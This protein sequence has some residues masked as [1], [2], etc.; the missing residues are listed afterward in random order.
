V[1]AID[2]RVQTFDPALQTMA[3]DSFIIANVY[4]PLTWHNKQLEL[5][6][7]LAL[8]WESPDDGLSWIFKL[9]PNV[10]FH[11]GNVCDAEAV[12]FHFDRI[13]DPETH[14]KRKSKMLKVKSIEALDP[15]T[16]QFNMHEPFSLWPIIMRDAFA[17][18]VSPTAV[19]KYGNEKYTE[20]PSGT[21][22]YKV[23]E[24]GGERVLLTKNHAYWRAD[25]YPVEE[26]ELLT[27]REPTTRLIMLEQGTID[28]C[29]ITFAHTEIAEKT[30][31]LRVLSAP[32]LQVR[33]VGFN[34]M[35]PPF[36]DVRVRRAANM[37]LNRGELVKFAFRG[38]ADPLL[39][40]LPTVMREFNKEM[41]TYSY[42]L[43]KA[44]AL[45][46]EAGYEKGVDVVLWSKDD[47]SDTN[48][49]VV[50]ADQLRHIGIRVEIIRYDRNV[51]WD[52]FDPYQTLDMQWFPTKPGVFDLYAAGWVGGESPH[53]YIDPLFRSTSTS[54][55]SYYKN[56]EV[57]RLLAEALK[58][59]DDDK[60]DEIYKHL[61]QVIVDDAPWI[62]CYS[63]RLLWG[64][65]PRIQNLSQHPAGEYE[66]H[67]VMFGGGTGRV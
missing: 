48:L 2:E 40:P 57:D 23:A 24:Q 45:M 32:Y 4:D 3:L 13:I 8:S 53:G 1:V 59:V 55:T 14:S 25:D 54:N 7:R 49:G 26:V 63:S 50:V 34:N 62:F 47:V 10:L 20:H 16:V 66:L 12:K 28:L 43:E 61:Q 60:R 44:R 15:L 38:N 21:G 33:Y 58:T 36:D 19:R 39:G 52:K 65:N 64:M 35:K 46:A 30:K 5:V 31:D 11:D 67:D 6:P 41:Q 56:E 51:Y 9:R 17:G 42:D 29:N 18:P 37:A 22:P 27:I